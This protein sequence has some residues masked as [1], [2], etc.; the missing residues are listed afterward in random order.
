MPEIIKRGC[1]KFT[2]DCTKCGCNYSYRLDELHHSYVT[3]T[4]YVACPQCGKQHI[5]HTR[6]GVRGAYEPR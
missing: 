4:D 5:H 6:T 3:G 2:A 1:D